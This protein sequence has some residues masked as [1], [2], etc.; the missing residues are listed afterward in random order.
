MRNA[1]AGLTSSYPISTYLKLEPGKAGAAAELRLA[2]DLDAAAAPL[3]RCVARTEGAWGQ[4][5]IGA[6]TLT[7]H[8][9]MEVGLR[10]TDGE[11]QA[12]RFLA[13]ADPAFS[14]TS[15]D[16]LAAAQGI[17]GFECVAAESPAPLEIP[18]TL[19]V[20]FHLTPRP[21]VK[22]G[23]ALTGRME[24]N[25][26]PGLRLSVQPGAGSGKLA[27]G[28][29]FGRTNGAL[30]VQDLSTWQASL[31][32]LSVAASLPNLPADARWR[33]D[34]SLS[35]GLSGAVAIE[36]LGGLFD[37][38]HNPGL[39]ASFPELAARHQEL[40]GGV[41]R[42]ALDAQAKLGWQTRWASSDE[43]V[44]SNILDPDE[45]KFSP[46]AQTRSEQQGQIQPRSL[47]EVLRG[48]GVGAAATFDL[49]AASASTADLYSPLR[50]AAIELSL[51]GARTSEI[52][53]G[54]Q[55]RVSRSS[56]SVTTS[57]AQ[58]SGAP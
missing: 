17:G 42:G 6:G 54:D 47:T 32:A 15:F 10:I 7:P 34:S 2:T 41:T 48:L 36:H 53:D 23:L 37:V 3:A 35:W 1:A 55:I 9:R 13:G 28:F 20:F 27:A 24:V 11:I 31:G 25:G 29:A 18:A 33:V 52:W 46:L 44:W 12:G 39:S 51:N 30:A 57:Q 21:Q 16:L 8:T 49:P 19:P 56:G 38:L 22:L 26:Q 50:P 43:V 14:W 45:R 4:M 5:I 40:I 58:I